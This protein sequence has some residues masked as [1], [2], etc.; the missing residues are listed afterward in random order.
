MQ[1]LGVQISRELF[2][3]WLLK[4]RSKGIK[5][6]LKVSLMPSFGVLKRMKLKNFEDQELPIFMLRQFF[7]DSSLYME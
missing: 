1:C 4:T 6:N 2:Y 3:G 5:E 7:I